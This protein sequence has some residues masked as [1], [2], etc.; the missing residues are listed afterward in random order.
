MN[1][2]NKKIETIIV[3]VLIFATVIL[4]LSCEK[5]EYKLRIYD[6]LADEPIYN[7]LIYNKTD[8]K[9][10]SSDY[11]GYVTLPHS[12]KGEQISIDAYGYKSKK[13][14]TLRI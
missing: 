11:N 9:A 2:N 4:M 5:Q 1:I 6:K 8:A 10:Y 13:N 12:Y 14:N 7:A 3:F